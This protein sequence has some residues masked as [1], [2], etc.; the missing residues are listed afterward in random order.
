[1]SKMQLLSLVLAVVIGVTLC[2]TPPPKLP[3]IGY[4]GSGYDLVT[5][6]PKPSVYSTNSADVGFKLRV[7]NFSYSQQQTTVDGR[8]LIPD[9]TQVRAIPACSFNSNADT[10]T[11]ETSYASTLSTSVSVSGSMNDIF[12][13]VSFSASASYQTMK[14]NTYKYKNIFVSTTGFCAAYEAFLEPLSF[15]VNN[16]F[17]KEVNYLP[18]KINQS[19]PYD[20]YYTFI[21]TYGT[22]YATE[23]K[24]GSQ[25]SRTYQFDQQSWSSMQYQQWDV[26]ATAQVEYKI[27]TGSASSE[28]NQS[29]KQ[30]KEFEQISSKLFVTVFG[31]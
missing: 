28:T 21:A 17:V 14:T 31:I 7:A 13:K 11:G 8:Y 9:Y 19:N 26:Q 2:M 12:T 25:Y 30:A 29:I 24:F 16:E 15:K 4:L 6:N 22:N 27:Y 3:N 5:G 20:P 1:M 18:L 10:N 23:L